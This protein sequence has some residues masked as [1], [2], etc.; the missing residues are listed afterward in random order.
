MGAATSPQ[1]CGSAPCCAA[2]E[3][4]R[5]SG[6]DDFR[7]NVTQDFSSM[8]IQ[9]E[10][11]TLA[12]SKE[13]I[14]K[15]SQ[16]LKYDM[17]LRP[18]ALGLSDAGQAHA[19][20]AENGGVFY[21][22][23]ET[24]QT[25]A[26]PS[27]AKAVNA[28]GE[29][30]KP[31]GGLGPWMSE[32]EA[33]SSAWWCCYSCCCSG[34][35]CTG[36]SRPFFA[37]CHCVLCRLTCDTPDCYIPSACTCIQSVLCCTMIGQLPSRE[38]HPRCLVCSTDF[39]GVVG[40]FEAVSKRGGSLQAEGMEQFDMVLFDSFIPCYCACCGVALAS[41]VTAA[42]FIWKLFCF[43]CKFSTQV[44]RQKDSICGCLFEYCW[45]VVQCRIPPHRQPNPVCAV[46]GW[47]LRQPT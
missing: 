40:G 36:V 6:G 43:Q 2:R 11:A 30:K 4:G 35:G 18:V 47:R 19:Q 9:E 15:T 42:A 44:P 21:T 33:L 7:E 22:A 32:E 31:R 45:V 17:P 41:P 38:G 1:T 20:S 25:P 3:A 10:S 12:L 34:F 16:E 46:C 8:P 26:L 27:T 29:K 39:C 28:T 37:S 23:G 14:K 13:N 5:D 24:H